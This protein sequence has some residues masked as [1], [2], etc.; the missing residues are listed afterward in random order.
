M[1]R[2]S[3]ILIPQNG[4]PGPS[5]GDFSGYSRYRL[6]RNIGLSEHE[7][8]ACYHA[9]CKSHKNR[10][11]HFPKKCSPYYN[12]LRQNGLYP[13]CCTSYPDRPTSFS[14]SALS[15]NTRS[16]RRCRE[17]SCQS[18]MVQ[19]KPRLFCLILARTDCSGEKSCKHPA[20]IRRSVAR[21][22]VLPP[23]IVFPSYM[24]AI[25]RYD[26]DQVMP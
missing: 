13:S 22:I 1:Y 14:K 19:T 24:S 7:N 25:S 21:L 9:D 4:F 11:E 18:L 15:A 20:S 2:D 23:R 16:S 10:G 8:V 5:N 26:C 12:H 17:R 6:G 3:M